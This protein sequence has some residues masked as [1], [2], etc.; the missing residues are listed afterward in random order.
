MSVKMPDTDR[1][2]KLNFVNWYLNG[3]SKNLKIQ[4]HRTIILLVVSPSRA[5]SF[6]LGPNIPL[7]AL[8]SNTLVLHSSLNVSDQVSHPYKRTSKIIVLY[9]LIFK[10]LEWSIQKFKD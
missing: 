8:F 7:N 10:F 1:E 2:A 9:I 5:T 4:I 3:V 6:L